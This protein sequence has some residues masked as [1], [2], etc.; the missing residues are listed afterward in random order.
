M[1]PRPSSRYNKRYADHA[2]YTLKISHQ[3]GIQG[4]YSYNSTRTSALDRTRWLNSCP[5]H[6]K[7]GKERQYFL[8]RRLGGPQRL[9]GHFE[10][11]KNFVRT[12]IR[13]RNHPASG[14]FTTLTILPWPP[15]FHPTIGHEGPAWPWPLYPQRGNTVPTAQKTEWTTA[16]VCT[17]AENLV[18]IVGFNPQTIKPVAS[19]YTYVMK[20][21][22]GRWGL[23][24]P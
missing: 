14:I 6:F 1:N 13:I 8:N 9:S 11:E 16:S 2:T 19:R 10:E 3:E 22:W 24:P 17:R 20:A 21:Y 15:K 23:V 5:G 7:T 18:P 12:R 4:E